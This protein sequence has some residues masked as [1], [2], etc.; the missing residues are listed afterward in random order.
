MSNYK[1][2][3]L[4]GESYQRCRLIEIRNPLN[5]TPEVTFTE[6]RITTVGETTLRDQPNTP[7]QIQYD[8]TTI[9]NL[10]DPETLLPTED[11]VTMGDLYIYLFSVYMHFANIRDTPPE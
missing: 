10:Y 3:T 2:T 6:E 7:I 5:Q 9:I 11:T 1:Q 4:T 8:P